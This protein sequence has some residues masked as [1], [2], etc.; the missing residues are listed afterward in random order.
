MTALPG[1]VRNASEL[2]WHCRHWHAPSILVP[3]ASRSRSSAAGSGNRAHSPPPKGAVGEQA[4]I[5]DTTPHVQVRFWL[6]GLAIASKQSG[7]LA[8]E[9]YR[10]AWTTNREL[11]KL[12]TFDQFEHCFTKKAVQKSSGRVCPVQVSIGI[13]RHNNSNCK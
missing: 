6:R 11:K 13:G 8:N 1:I 4:A 9:E 10:I 5:P 12:S 3:V 2:H 7:L